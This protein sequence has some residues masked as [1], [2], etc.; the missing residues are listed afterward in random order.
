MYCKRWVLQD[1]DELSF[2]YQLT[3]QFKP[4]A[5][6]WNVIEAHAGHI[7]AGSI[8]ARHKPSRYRIDP[9]H[10][11]DGNGF[12]SFLC[13]QCRVETGDNRCHLRT[14]SSAASFGSRS[15]WPF[16]QRVSIVTLSFVYP[17]SRRPWRT[18][19]T[20]CPDSPARFGLRNPTTG[21]A[22]CC[23]FP[24]SGHAAAA[25]PTNAMNSRRL[26]ASPAPRTTSG[27]QKNIT[28]LDRELSFANIQAA[29]PMS[30]LG[31]KRTSWLADGMSALPPK[32]DIGT[33]SRNVRFVPKDGVI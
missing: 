9:G 25:P 11:N 7:A 1:G 5:S 32:A 20:N 10:K 19:A 4:F 24:A 22:D 27:Y 17:D 23:A 14:T 15:V 26:M 33:Q 6:N 2:G 21:N 13:R 3:Q 18:A 30:A 8:D 28:F 31:Q 12:A 29:A 16:A